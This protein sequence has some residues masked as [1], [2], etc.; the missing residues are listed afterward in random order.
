ME[1]IVF[2]D[3]N[4][5]S[6]EIRRPSFAHEWIEYGETETTDV[7]ERLKGATIA[8]TN[9]VRLSEAELSR[10]P[11]L[12]FIA[13]AATGVDV[14]DLEY[15]RRAGLA[16]SNVRN[17]ARHSVPEHAL[18]LMLALRRNLL[19]YRSD[20]QNGAWSSA[21]A[22]CLFEHPI[23]DLYGSTLGIIGHGVLGQAMEKLAR[24]F[25]MRVL[26]SEHKGSAEIREGRTSF[27][28]VL[29]ESDV[30]TL[31]APLN[32]A[33]RNMIGA[34]EFE[35]MKRSAILI[36]TARGGLVDEVA[37]CDALRR[38]VIAGAGFDVL[39]KEPPREG[40]PL[41]DLQLPNFIL[42]PHNAWASR[43]AMQALANQLIENLEAF[44]RG[45]PQN[46]V[47]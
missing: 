7:L 37:L 41:L 13:V 44:V 27:D 6:A 10:L 34:A 19:S 40:N 4:S 21:H 45:T 12:R 30:L 31:H 3:R 20:V 11:A 1:H 14:I 28:E 17:Y 33:T 25:G 36:N 39:T 8:I 18:M 29:V 47:K 23:H 5:L 16:V 22:F 24:A 43:E 26:I 9:K 32:E 38:S 2:L 42:T 15:C 35:K 46:L